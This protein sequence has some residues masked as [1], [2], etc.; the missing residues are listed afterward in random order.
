MAAEGG[1]TTSP[2]GAPATTGPAIA[3]QV[4]RILSGERG[5]LTGEIVDI[6]ARDLELSKER[7]ER[8]ARER[9]RKRETFYSDLLYTI[10]GLHYSEQDARITWMNLLTHKWEMSERMGRNVGISVAALDYFM[11]VVG[12][13][14]QVR[15]IDS[16]RYI[17]TERLAATDGLTGLFNHRYLQ[18]KLRNELRRAEEA[19]Q[20][21]SLLMIDIDHF[22]HYNDNL[23]HVAGDVARRSSARSSRGTSSPA[24]AARSSPSSST[25][26]R[27]GWRPR[28]PS[29][30]G[31]RWPRSRSSR[32]AAG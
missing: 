6:A 26:S 15:I 20:P 22:K 30:S 21:L 19:G 10:T 31:C 12:S 2:A 14:D 27:S 5:V 1:R 3:E 13:L 24:T 23:G 9:E 28:L 8:L 7:E 32:R 18:E 25:A 16:S 17:E 29:A 11:N 4:E